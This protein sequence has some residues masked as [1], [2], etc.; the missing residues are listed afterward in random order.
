MIA[1]PAIMSGRVCLGDGISLTHGADAPA[2]EDKQEYG[3][4]HGE[5]LM[6]SIVEVGA[7]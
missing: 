6:V 3:G 7:A 2:V 4:W 5:F 1:Q